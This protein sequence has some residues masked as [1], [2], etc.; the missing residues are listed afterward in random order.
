MDLSGNSL[1]RFWSTIIFAVLVI[2]GAIQMFRVNP[3]NGR[4]DAETP[5]IYSEG[6]IVNEK[7]F[8]GSG[9]FL[10]FPIKLNRRKT[11]SGSF[12][13]L[14]KKGVVSCLVLDEKNFEL[15]QAGASHTSR[16]ATGYLPRGT[17]NLVLEPGNYQLVF[18][19]RD[20]SEKPVE[21]KFG[22]R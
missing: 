15:L 12:T 9:R 22:L 2:L 14:T 17:V 16:S 3:P 6:E 13:V 7:I 4:R 5:A 20:P 18:D 19:N 8:V 1:L 21:V 10:A 11:L